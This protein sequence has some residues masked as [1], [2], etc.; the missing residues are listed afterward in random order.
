MLVGITG[1]SGFIGS[2]LARRHAYAGDQVRCL[3]R[4]PGRPAYAGTANVVADLAAPDDRLRRFADGL[5]VL[6]HCAAEIREPARMAAVNV[7]GTRALI[8][9]AAGRVGRWVQLSS[10]GVYGPRRDGVVIE[11]TPPAP[12]GAYEKSKAAGDSLVLEACADCR[13]RSAV[14]V[15]PSIVFGDGMRNQS[16]AQWADVIERGLFFFIGPAGASANYVDVSNVVDALI[17]CAV[18]PEAH[19]RVY[20]VSDWCTIEAFVA[21]IATAIGRPRPRLRLPERPV[22]AAVRGVGRVTALPLTDARIDALVSRCRY[23]TARIERELG[24]RLAV[25]IADGLA[26]MLARRRA[27]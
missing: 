15:R 16:I 20:N 24:Y 5:D 18:T 10:V 2:A 22:R 6:Y 23:S 12:V 17:L 27:A 14:I 21:A 25:P 7:E 11:E 9:A 1:A 4:V 8:G 26:R 13:L 19:G 3:T